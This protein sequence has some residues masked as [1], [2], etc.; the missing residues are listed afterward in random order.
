MYNRKVRTLIN[1]AS[2]VIAVLSSTLLANPQVDSLFRSFQ[3]NVPGAAVGIYR[4]GQTIYEQGYGLREVSTSSAVT[5]TT[6]FRIASLSKQFTA[7]A[8][9]ILIEKGRLSLETKLTEIFPAF[10]A[11]ANKITIRNLLNH[12][13]GLPDY[14]G[15]ISG[16]GQVSDYDILNILQR[17]S[18]PSFAAGSRYSY[19]NGGYVLLGLIVENVSQMLFSDFLKSQVFNRLGMENTWM[20]E[21]FLAQAIPERAYGYSAQGGSFALTDQSATSATRGDGGVYTS[22]REW[23]H[24]DQALNSNIL[25]SEGLR[26][27]MFTPG[28][29]N[30]GSP[31]HYG[32][33]WMLDSNGGQSH[34]GSSIGF[35][36]A[37]RRYPNRNLTVVVF[38]NRANVSPWDTAIRV[39]ALYP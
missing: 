16:P 39:A 37:V 32:F 15:L 8:V 7:M 11:Y 38:M 19:S 6:N 36:T 13:G 23:L 31:I 18:S 33:G 3:G 14:E 21:R 25:I 30:N 2:C 9:L 5:P 27:L 24:W 28:K 10:P 34:T 17:Q 12:T 4:G 22:V 35:R 26:K 29:L 20:Y 1:W